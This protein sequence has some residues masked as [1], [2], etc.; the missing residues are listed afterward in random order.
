MTTSKGKTPWGGRFSESPE[1]EVVAFGASLPVDKKMWREDIQGSLAHA[2]ML[3]S[4]GILSAE[5]LAAIRQG[6][7]QVASEIEEGTFNWDLFDEDVHMAVEKRLTE[8]VGRPGAKLHTARSRND[9]VA[10]DTR[11]YVRKKLFELAGAILELRVVLLGL[12]EKHMDVYMPGYTHLQKAQPLLFSHHMLA[13]DQMLVRDFI[14]VKR[15]YKN[16][17]VLPL[18]SAALAGTT[19]PVDRELVRE[20]LG[21]EKITT[22]SLDAVSDRDFLLDSS[23]AC[24]VLQMHLSRLS[25]EIILWATEEFG[26]IKLSDKYSTGSSIMPQKKNPDFA[27]LIRGKT[28]RVFASLMQLLV[29]LKSLPLAYN[30]DMQE[31]KEFAFDALETAITSSKVMAG[32]LA[33]MNVNQD[34]MKEA[35]AGGFS[36]ATDLADWLVGEGIA[37]REAHEIVGKVVIF[38]EQRGLSLQEMSIMDYKE[39]HPAFNNSVLDAVLIENVVNRRI[40]FGG[41]ATSQVES[42]L[43][44]ARKE[45]DKDQ[46]L[47]SKT[48][49][50]LA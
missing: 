23:Y 10:T 33:T 36:A 11:L 28:G 9:Q 20:E 24:S 48:M 7:A 32:M 4:I 41:T 31:D 26:F 12:A 19:Y 50:P 5:E 18:G 2:K 42:A 37:F 27:E 43:I 25:E 45:L 47:L 38:A 44:A 16:T 14:R 22:N 13:Y 17:D 46:E 30:K 40:S 34:V 3:E 6:L 15:A 29:T 49:M 21:F 1:S 35:S 8:I 39:V